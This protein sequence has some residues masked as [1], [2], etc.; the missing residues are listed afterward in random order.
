MNCVATFGCIT[1]PEH[2]KEKHSN[3]VAKTVNKSYVL[4]KF[5]R[6]PGVQS[7][8]LENNNSHKIRK[9]VS[10]QLGHGSDDSD[11]TETD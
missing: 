3:A 9:V 7:A 4:E 1:F 5:E 11:A 10:A 8:T 2:L 6:Y